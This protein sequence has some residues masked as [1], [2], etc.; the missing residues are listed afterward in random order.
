[1]LPPGPEDGERSALGP[2]ADNLLDL[3][4]GFVVGSMFPALQQPLDCAKE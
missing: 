2:L 1:M 3:L 4:P